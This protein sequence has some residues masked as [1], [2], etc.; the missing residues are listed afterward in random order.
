MGYKVKN[1]ALKGKS[2]V[3]WCCECAQAVNAKLTS[4]KKIYPHRKDLAGIPIWQCGQCNNFVGC[5]P[6]GELPIGSIPTPEIRAERKKIHGLID[7]IWK[8][9]LLKR[10]ELYGMISERLGREFHAGSIS[11]MSE[12]K[13]VV[14]IIDEIKLLGFD[15]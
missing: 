11:S 9:R 7:P 6:G 1:N 14:E 3:I 2:I 5:H 13:R 15:E 8:S 4:G 10:T 12:A